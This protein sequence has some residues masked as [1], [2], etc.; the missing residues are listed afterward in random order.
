MNL[1]ELFRGLTGPE[2][3][4]KLPR[5]DSGP[6]PI[7]ARVKPHYYWATMLGHCANGAQRDTGSVAHVLDSLSLTNTSLCGRKPG[8]RS[9]GW[10]EPLPDPLPKWAQPCSRCGVHL[11]SQ[12][13][14]NEAP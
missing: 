10:S 12:E 11:T 9:A 4:P 2:E 13:S 8:R 6:S 14:P 7:P 3:V 1:A 5:Q